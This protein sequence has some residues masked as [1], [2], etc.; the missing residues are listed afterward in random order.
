MLVQRVLLPDSSAESWTVL[1]DDHRPVEPVERWLAYLS[2][3]KRSPNT[4][5]GYAHDLKDWFGF[6]AGHGLDWQAVKLEDLGDFVAWLRLPPQV[7]TGEVLALPSVAEHCGDS[8]IHR[9]LSAL[10]AF[11]EFHAR[12]GLDLGELLVTWRPYAGARTSWKAFLHHVAKDRPQRRRTIKLKPPRLRPRVLGVRQVQA[13]LD[14]CDHL[15]DRLLFALLYDTGVRI[16]EALGL[17]HEDLAVAER[18]LTVTPRLNDNR[19]R[20]KSPEPRTIPVSEAL[21]R[22]YAD[23][24]EGEYGD[25]DSDYVFVNLWGGPLGRPLVYNSV[26]DLVVRVRRR[27]GIAFDPHWFRHTYATELLRRATPMETVAQLLGH[28]SVST[29]ID[30]YGHLTPED[31]RRQLQAVGWFRDRQV[32]L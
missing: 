17:R 20:T 15:R 7:R 23:Y 4:V 2:A 32:R 10:S 29:T 18:E 21:V 26:Y 13:I 30:F 11:Y 22:L 12:H 16:G 24:L 28:A 6:L 8:T 27:T 19:A 31:A 3:T 25:L 5:K 1:G 9:K 14:A